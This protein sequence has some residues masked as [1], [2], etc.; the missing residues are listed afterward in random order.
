MIVKKD[1]KGTKILAYPWN[2]FE[3]CWCLDEL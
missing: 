2:L 1:S 3:S